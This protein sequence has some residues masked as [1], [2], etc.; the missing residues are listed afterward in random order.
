[1]NL[2]N[3]RRG[4]KI[5]TLEGH[6]GDGSGQVFSPDGRTLYTAAGDSTLM[7]WDVAGDRRLGSPLFRTG[8]RTIPEDAFPPG[9]AVSPDGTTL[10]VARLDGRVDLIDAETSAQD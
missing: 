10:A 9:F 3:V 6:S 2:W 5:E 1:M 8:L 4:V 7:I